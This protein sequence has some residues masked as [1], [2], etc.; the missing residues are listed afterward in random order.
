[1]SKIVEVLGIPPD[2]ILDRATRRDRFFE[3]GTGGTWV[4]KRHRDGRN[5]SVHYY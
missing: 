5:V 2:H 3:R 1:M 4:L